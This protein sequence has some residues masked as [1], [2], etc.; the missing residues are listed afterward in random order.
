MP[1][2]ARKDSFGQELVVENI[3]FEDQGKY[4]CQG[5]NDESQVP[6][7][8][9][10]DL[11]VECKFTLDYDIARFENFLSIVKHLNTA[12]RYQR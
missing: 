4:E 2:N 10:F 9:S 6:I 1:A 3:Q 11:S 7:R 5:I 12:A 8:R